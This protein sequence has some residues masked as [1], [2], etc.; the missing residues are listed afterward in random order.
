MSLNLTLQTDTNTSFQV[1]VSGEV[2][3]DKGILLLHD[4]W[5]VLD[6]NIEW[7][8]AFATQ[9][10]RALVIDLYDGYHPEDAQTA[11][12]HMRNLDQTL[13]NH[14]LQAALA[15]LHQTERNVAVLGWSLGGLQAQ[16]AAV[17]APEQVNAL[18]FYYCRLLL[19]ET[20]LAPLNAPILGIFSETERTWPEKQQKL[21]A[22]AQKLDKTFESHSYNADHGF[23]N[24]T[25]PRFDAEATAQSKQVVET[26]L[27]QCW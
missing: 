8:D 5:G 14:K 20:N 9:G 26:F 23:V 15:Y 25:S 24:P 22:L 4:W 1:Y 16:Y 7:A 6:Y 10:Y 13:A 27:Q 11:G 18:V 17:I 21:Q 19:D 12:E 2:A 3:A